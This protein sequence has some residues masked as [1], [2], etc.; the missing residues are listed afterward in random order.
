M[1]IYTKD[2]YSFI[3]VPDD[4]RVASFRILFIWIGFIVVAATMA[5]GGALGSQMS[6]SD[7]VV[8]LF[9]GNIF[10]SIIAFISGYIGAKTGLSF[11][12][13]AEKVF[14]NGSWRLA[15]I[16]VPLVL[17][18]WFA[19][20]SSIF[21]GFVGGA[22][23]LTDE[24]TRFV[25]VGAALVFATSSYF[26]IKGVGLV[27]YFLVPI[28]VVFGL[29][30]LYLVI[31]DSSLRF[32][33]SDTKLD[34]WGG[35][36]LVLSSW[37]FSALLVIPDLTR[38]AKTPLK[39][40]VIAAGGILLANTISMGVGALAASYTGESDP[41][42][43][44]LSL[45]FLPIA[46]VLSLASIWSTNDNNMYSSALNISRMF[47]ISRRRAVVFLTLA[48]AFGAYFNPAGVGM[49]FDI[50]IF[51]GSSAPALGGIV[52]GAYLLRDFIDHDR[53]SAWVA[54]LS[55]FSASFLSYYIGGAWLIP[56][57]LFGGLLFWV[58]LSLVN[59]LVQE[60]RIASN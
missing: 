13:L 35:V 33:F 37:I 11:S 41:S 31:D 53:R 12:L 36:S 15:S 29:Y 60:R 40:G 43:V 19:I 39:G 30:A 58:I 23:E 20:Q 10:L 34:F 47:S 55:W 26:G 4:V 48:A 51:M 49:L 25:M 57:G 24:S 14:V 5:I 45:G 38:F 17:T 46:F 32:G 6:Q 59:S 27:S 3:Q 52:L 42:T 16:Y 44:L 22:F 56:V 7:F 21:G 50:L 8:A 1:S 54:L 28:V 18:G 2:D 9:A